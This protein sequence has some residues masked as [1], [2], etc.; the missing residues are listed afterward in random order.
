M[1]AEA[2]KMAERFQLI[3]HKGASVVVLDLSNLKDEKEIIGFLRMRNGMQTPHCLLVDLTS[4]HFTESTVKEAKES[5]MA[6]QAVIKGFA[7]VSTNSS[8]SMLAGV[9]GG[10]SGMSIATYGTR[11]EAMDWLAEQ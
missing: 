7:M 11:Q 5:T 8:A 9:V 2:K 1:A 10:F 4:T 3:T 6:M